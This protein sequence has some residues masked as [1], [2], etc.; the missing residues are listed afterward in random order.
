MLSKELFEELCKLHKLIYKLKSDIIEDGSNNNIIDNINDI[1]KY[2]EDFINDKDYDK[3][4]ISFIILCA[5][6]MLESPASF[7]TW[8]EYHDTPNDIDLP[9]QGSFTPQSWYDRQRKQS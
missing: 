9:Y 5:N 2:L 6:K 4:D 8:L 1:I 3:D 7:Q